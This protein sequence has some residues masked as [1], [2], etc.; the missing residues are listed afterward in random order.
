M[1]IKETELA[2][3]AGFIDGEGNI[4]W[5]GT[6]T[7]K[8][9]NRSRCYGNIVLQVAQV[10][11]EPLDRVLKTLGTGRIYGP[12]HYNKAKNKQPYYL[13]SAVSNQAVDAL[14]KIEKYLSPIKKK[15]FLDTLELLKEYKKR[16]K[17]IK[18]LGGKY[19]EK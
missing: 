4:R 8:Q 17:L 6:K 14:S 2:W 5:N 7:K 19:Y 9:G 12:Y 18:G 11:K 13:Y 3:C 16:P 10:H 15:Q 1:K